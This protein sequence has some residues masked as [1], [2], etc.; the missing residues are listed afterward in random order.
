MGATALVKALLLTENYLIA[1]FSL[2]SLDSALL[3]AKK[4]AVMALVFA[5]MAIVLIM[6]GFQPSSPSPTKTTI[7]EILADPSSWENKL[8]QAEGIIDGV[9]TI[10]EIK[11]PFNYWLIGKTDEADR[12][13]VL[14]KGKETLRVGETALVTG[15]VKCGY[16]QKLTSEGWVNSTLVYYIEAQAVS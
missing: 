11:L 7:S 9:V 8:V 6:V 12:I 3:S 5:T 1:K 14:W 2:L 13:G 4:I 15:I 16:E 10:P